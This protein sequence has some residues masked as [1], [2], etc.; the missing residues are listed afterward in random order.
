MIMQP[1]KRHKKTTPVSSVLG[2]G[3]LI[4]AA[5]VIVFLFVRTII[6]AVPIPAL[7]ADDLTGSLTSRR[8]LVARVEELEDAIDTFRI[9]QDE[10][11]I[12]RKENESLK[13]ELG[14]SAAPEGVLARVLTT[15]ERN[16]YETMLIDAGSDDGVTEG[17][18]VYAFDSVALGTIAEVSAR[19]ATVRRG[20]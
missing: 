18:V 12:L 7:S 10:V 4:L 9:G 8:A 3:V 6:T 20:R 1:F 16:L 5:I 11:S 13:A 19:R 2:S 14:R 15:P 17:Q